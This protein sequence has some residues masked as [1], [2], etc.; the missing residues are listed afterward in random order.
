MDIDT[1]TKIVPAGDFLIG[2]RALSRK[3]ASDGF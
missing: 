1:S 3:A 2:D